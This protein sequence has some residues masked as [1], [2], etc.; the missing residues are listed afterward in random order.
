MVDKFLEFLDD[1]TRRSI[2]DFSPKPCACAKNA[3]IGASA[4]GINIPSMA[5]SDDRAFGMGKL[6]DFRAACSRRGLD[7]MVAVQKRNAGDFFK[8]LVL[9]FPFFKIEGEQ[10]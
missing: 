8:V 7:D 4:R 10:I 9:K 2:A 1:I 5:I 3:L 6:V